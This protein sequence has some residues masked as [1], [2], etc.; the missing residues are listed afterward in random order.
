MTLGNIY[1]PSSGDQPKF[2]K[3][4]FNKITSFDNELIV[5]GGDWNIAVNPTLDTNHPSN[6][7]RNRSRGKY[8][9]LLNA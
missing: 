8:K 7:N 6:V 1:E 5:V 3:E 9:S 2:F 4:M